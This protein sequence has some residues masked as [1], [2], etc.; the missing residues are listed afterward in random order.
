M[1]SPKNITAETL[2]RYVRAMENA[3][4]NNVETLYRLL[5]GQVEAMEFVVRP[6]AADIIGTKLQELTLKKDLLVCAINRRGRIIAP[7]GQD[8]I[9][10]GDIVVIVTTQKG[11]RDLSDIV[12]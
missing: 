3:S 11:I 2:V 9:E 6:G 12:R 1:V 7:T 4:G 8:T 5:D 10:P